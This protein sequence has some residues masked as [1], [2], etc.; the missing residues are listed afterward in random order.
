MAMLNIDRSLKKILNTSGSNSFKDKGKGVNY[1]SSGGLSTPFPNSSNQQKFPVTYYTQAK[2]VVVDG[3]PVYYAGGKQNAPKPSVVKRV[4]SLIP[5]DKKVP[6]IFET[7]KQYLQEYIKN[8]E[9]ANGT[10]FTPSEKQRYIK[11]EL[12]E[13]QPVVSRFTTYH[14]DYMP[15]RTVFFTDNKYN[16]STP[17]FEMSAL[18]E[19]WHEKTEGNPQEQDDEVAA[20]QYARDRM[21]KDLQGRNMV[22]KHHYGFDSVEDKN[23]KTVLIPPEEFLKTTYEQSQLKQGSPY[24]SYEDYKAEV[25]RR[26]SVDWH[27]KAIPS[28][29]LQVE[30][31]FLEFDKW[32][33]PIGHEGRHTSQAA[34]ELGLKEIPVTV[35]QRRYSREWEKPP[36]PWQSINNNKVKTLLNAP[37]YK[38]QAVPNE[39][40]YTGDY[41]IDE[42]KLEKEKKE[43]WEKDER[44][45]LERI[46]ASEQRIKELEAQRKVLEDSYTDEEKV[47][48]I[49]LEQEIENKDVSKSR[50]LVDSETFIKW[51]DWHALYGPEKAIEMIDK[52][53]NKK[54]FN[55]QQKV[56]VIDVLAK[57]LEDYFPSGIFA[58]DQGKDRLNQMQLERLKKLQE[59]Y[60]YPKPVIFPKPIYVVD[61][62][63]V[64]Q[65]KQITKPPEN[66][67]EKQVRNRAHNLI[68]QYPHLI[69]EF[70][71]M[72][73]SSA[74]VFYQYGGPKEKQI[75]H[76]E[77]GA[78]PTPEG[79]QIGITFVDV[80]PDKQL[81]SRKH[82]YL[83][84]ASTA[85]HELGHEKQFRGEE[86]FQYT[87][88]DDNRLTGNEPL[89]EYFNK[90]FEKE[91]EMYAQSQILDINKGRFKNTRIFLT[92]EEVA[93]LHVTPKKQVEEKQ[94]SGEIPT[95]EEL[96]QRVK[97]YYQQVE[98]N[99]TAGI[100][101]LDQG[102]DRKGW[103]QATPQ[104]QLKGVESGEKPTAL[105][106]VESFNNS[107]VDTSLPY[108][109]VSFDEKNKHMG[110]QRIYYQPT[111]DGLNNAN[112]VLNIIQKKQFSD[113]D[114]IELGK[115]FGYEED[116]INNFLWATK[117]NLPLYRDGKV[118]NYDNGKSRTPEELREYNKKYY[119][120]ANKKRQERIKQLL[121][122][123]SQ[124][125]SY[126]KPNKGVDVVSLDVNEEARR[127]LNLR[128]EDLQH[129]VSSL[130]DEEMEQLQREKEEDKLEKQKL[131]EQIEETSKLLRERAN[132]R[133]YYNVER[134]REA[135][136]KFYA[137]LSPEE[138]QELINTLNEYKLHAV[139]KRKD[140]VITPEIEEKAHTLWDIPE[141]ELE[142]QIKKLPTQEEEI[143]SQLPVIEEINN[144]N[145]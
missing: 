138:K 33:R 15:P 6:V 49:L 129:S 89:E 101:L 115:L 68:K 20:E 118:I 141:E 64:F 72:N 145:I 94:Q 124:R 133:K 102:K 53:M 142:S 74:V 44:E 126:V 143:Q 30:I 18:H 121:L 97:E 19:Y 60:Y 114:H 3:K 127:L 52:E 8:Q 76:G 65:A 106:A 95:K 83:D 41:K 144:E 25:L 54:G 22:F 85:F 14:N 104:E 77:H 131:R 13:M 134:R 66:V 43:Y 37:T 111:Q 117:N 107:Y 81:Q 17:H 40:V 73:P 50:E 139:A 78:G 34:V 67:F 135:S 56:W 88:N 96:K 39:Y 71:K 90:P 119:E 7:K 61:T 103:P 130:S 31:P 1:F 105:V 108:L 112:K 38:E 16:K 113:S 10:K 35:E 29:K 84:I 116:E 24:Q 2:K 110:H 92:P 12:K 36:Y 28:K 93:L 98:E 86:G 87:A 123:K 122:A 136:K 4:Y 70:E 109:E 48:M 11:T 55:V 9:L 80:A 128:T 120:E 140:L 45:R 26:S 59:V 82:E 79:E 100:Q 125:P 42:E 47:K 75:Y 62:N 137:N 69:T 99:K 132:R 46:K 58:N 23:I 57:E 21:Q 5:D 27:K 51:K 91:A 63:E 32:G